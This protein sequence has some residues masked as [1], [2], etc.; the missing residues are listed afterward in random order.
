MQY[1]V[2]VTHGH[3]GCDAMN[4]SR[5]V[6]AIYPESR[7]MYNHINKIDFIRFK[8]YII[9]FYNYYVMLQKFKITSCAFILC[10]FGLTLMT[11]SPVFAADGDGFTVCDNMPDHCEQ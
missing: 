11:M 5:G 7:V 1:L 3:A 10:L 9:G 4:S 2:D 6:I 8:T